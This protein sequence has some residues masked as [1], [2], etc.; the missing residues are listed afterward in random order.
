MLIKLCMFII[1][2]WLGA[3]GGADKISKNWRRL[4]IPILISL[5]RWNWWGLLLGYP[6]RM[7]YGIP[8]WNDRGSYVGRYFYKLAKKDEY[9]A[10]IYTRIFF[11]I[12]YGIC[13]AT[14]THNLWPI[15][16][17]GIVVPYFGAI[18]KK[19]RQIVAFGTILN[20]EEIIIWGIVGIC[21][22]L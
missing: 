5:V 12:I 6:I 13:I 11:G 10:S 16:I 4:G 22:C 3:L 1:C 8:C 9:L 14:V 21:A 15:L 19:Q 7:G 17:L 18:R 20:I 2:G